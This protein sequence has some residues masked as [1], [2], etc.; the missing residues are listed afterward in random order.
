MFFDLSIL[1]WTS[2]EERVD[3]RMEEKFKFRIIRFPC[4]DYIDFVAT[5]SPWIARN[6]I[7]EI[8]QQGIQTICTVCLLLETMRSG[9]YAKSSTWCDI[10]T[11]SNHHSLAQDYSACLW[12][13]MPI[14][15]DSMCS[16]GRRL[17]GNFD[18]QELGGARRT[19]GRDT[20]LVLPEIGVTWAAGR[21]LPLPGDM[22]DA[23]LPRAE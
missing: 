3:D 4:N 17:G 20:A 16:H 19:V 23:V 9:L 13:A 1:V 12:C 11:E 14:Y 18:Q 10:N 5:S 22:W 8:T 15:V 2:L 7:G 6:T 21:P